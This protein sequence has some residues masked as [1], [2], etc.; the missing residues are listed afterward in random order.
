MQLYLDVLISVHIQDSVRPDIIRFL[1]R[2]VLSNQPSIVH[3]LSSLPSISG[4]GLGMRRAA[5]FCF[6]IS[7]SIRRNSTLF[8]ITFSFVIT[9]S[10]IAYALLWA[11]TL[12]LGLYIF[13]GTHYWNYRICEILWIPCNYHFR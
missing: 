8:T 5:L 10:M 2:P 13:F 9:G 1:Y 12:C 6:S 7:V 11:G 4:N 3:H